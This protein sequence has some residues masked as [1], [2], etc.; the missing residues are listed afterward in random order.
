MDEALEVLTGRRAGSPE[1]EGTIN[2]AIDRA[3]EELAARLRD[4]AGPRDKGAS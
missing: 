4:F 3:V 2:H 1:E